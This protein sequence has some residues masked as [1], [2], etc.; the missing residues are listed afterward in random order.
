MV[1]VVCVLMF[2]GLWSERFYR[3]QKWV[4]VVDIVGCTTSINPDLAWLLCHDRIELSA[5]I[6]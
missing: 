2:G 5:D 4:I 1:L 6:V 3:W